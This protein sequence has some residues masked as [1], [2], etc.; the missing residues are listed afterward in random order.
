[1]Y[2]IK[3]ALK[4]IVRNKGRNL[5]VGAILL[6]II[7][8]T[9]VAFSIN[10][11]TTGIIDNYKDQFGTEVTIVRNM[12]KVQEM[13]VNGQSNIRFEDKSPAHFLTFGNSE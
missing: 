4:N 6:G 5:L 13:I 7:T 9:V 8:S 11:T 1:M 10:S 3:N 2:I 12:K